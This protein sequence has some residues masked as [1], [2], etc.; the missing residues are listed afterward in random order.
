[1]LQL[2]NIRK[3]YTTAS[4]T[5]KALDGV[6][7][8]FRENEF[9][10]VLGPSGSGKTTMLNI[11]GGLDQYDSGDLIIDGT[12]TKKYRDRDWDT[13]RN[14]RIGF[15]FQSY[16]LIPHQTVLANVELALTL[17]GVGRNERRQR[18]T[19]AL[20]RVGLSD[21]IHKRPNQL[22]GGQMQRV[23]V[24]RALINDPEIL[25]A[26]E[27]TGAL[28]STTSTQ[29]ME[30][31]T[32]IAKER[33]V[34]MVT[35]NPELAEEYATRTINLFDGKVTHDS[36]PFHPVTG[37]TTT[38]RPIRHASMSFLTA[39]ALSF[40]NLMTKKGRTIMTAVAGSIGIIGIAAI[41]SLA[42]GVNNYIKTIEEE[43]LSLYPLQI[44]STGF[45]MM[46]FFNV[47]VD[48]PGDD[49][50]GGDEGDSDEAEEA[51]DLTI[52]EMRI[53]ADMISGVRNNDLKSLKSYFEG[54]GNRIHDYTNLIMYDYGVTP[55]IYSNEATGTQRQ[56]NPNNSLDAIMG[57]GMLN[58][59]LGA[60]AGLATGSG[61]M[62]VF[63]PMID[64]L[65]MLEAQ[66][67]VV[68]GRWATE[69]DEAVLVLAPGGVVSD[70]VLFSMGLRDQREFDD[71]VRAVV[72]D[73]E[74]VIEGEPLEFTPEELMDVTFKIV[75]RANTF[76]HD[77]D[78]DLWISRAEDEAFMQEQIEQGTVLR[79]VGVVEQAEDGITMLQP[80][81]AY[82]PR[83]QEFL[84]D[85]ARNTDVVKAQLKNPEL[86]ILSGRTFADELEN[87]ERGG[88]DFESLLGF[89]AAALDEA[90]GGLGGGFDASA[91]AV[92][93]SA[94]SG[95][96]EFDPS[97][98]GDVPPMDIGQVIGGL[99]VDVNEAA[100]EALMGALMMDFI[101]SSYYNPLAPPEEAIAAFAEYLNSPQAQAIIAAG[102]GNVIDV[103]QLNAQ[104]QAT[105]TIYM[106]SVMQTVLGAMEAQIV[107]AMTTMMNG[108][109]SN[110]AGAFSGFGGL[111]DAFAGLMD[112]D[113][114]EEQ[115]RALM[116]AMLA[117]ENTTFE[118]NL[119]KFDYA[120]LAKPTRIDIYPRDF[121]SKE[122]I[123]QILEDYNE[124]MEAEGRE[125]QVITYTDFVGAIMSSVT[126]II[127]MIGY[128][129]IAFISIS[130]VVSSIM[131]GIIT[132]VSVLER[133]KEIGILRSIGASKGDIGRVFNAETLIVGLAAGVLGVGSVALGTIPVNAIVEQV[134]G[135]SRITILPWQAAA[136]LVAISMFL[137][138]VAGL[139]PSS[140]A[141]RKDPVEALRSE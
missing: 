89:D 129:L 47:H 110:L 85:E 136:I 37:S 31:L 105:L 137:S 16:N 19:D 56:V 36:D 48:V 124:R 55:L 45:D 14:N 80:G 2:T 106:M 88:V 65:D 70:F 40:N 108:L 6:S 123:T 114:D 32:E 139:I 83:L 91:L 130:L 22:S 117:G 126:T 12:S 87:P 127:N 13:Y 49:T 107:G 24:A 111:G 112:F 119:R 76:T 29:I 71:M 23:A 81:I 121:E 135:V 133:R 82:S 18:A 26:D 95:A 93:T 8:A 86:N 73:E 115:V 140:A 15:V 63:F 84:I 77:V 42:N 141:S 101:G 116:M 104:L 17:S 30:L 67:D 43:T 96:F 35:H 57:G 92:D 34:I 27:P 33:L 21:H 90:L 102:I 50:D 39:I 79:I 138:F 1:M 78:H 109:T 72:N 94:L 118:G 20:K 66:Y 99:D 113:I 122:E 132:Y 44:E 125:E 60:I 131:I 54:E 5:Q 10:A 53:V 61:V 7:I 64:S 38:D 9:V 120:D 28:D 4:F 75:N 58:S 51:D 59:S 128:V 52:S 98:M 103:E 11:V 62:N 69:P 3:S 68:A 46:S 41:L 97:A 100:L 134:L 74:I 25:L